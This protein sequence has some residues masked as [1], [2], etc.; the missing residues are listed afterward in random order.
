MG[1]G[2]RGWGGGKKARA[3]VNW[4]L[5]F[6]LNENGVQFQITQPMTAILSNINSH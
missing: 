1:G 2:G 6:E 3:F 5:T 4:C